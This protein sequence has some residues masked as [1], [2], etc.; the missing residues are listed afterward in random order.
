MDKSEALLLSKKIKE[1]QRNRVNRVCEVVKE[2]NGIIT[3][4]VN[5]K[6]IYSGNCIANRIVKVKLVKKVTDYCS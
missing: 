1:N 2:K 4:T 5:H 3:R 6:N